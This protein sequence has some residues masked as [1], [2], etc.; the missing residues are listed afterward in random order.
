[1]RLLWLI[2]NVQAAGGPMRAA[3]FDPESPDY[4]V[5]DAILTRATMVKPFAD[6]RL[7]AHDRID[8]LEKRVK[9]VEIEQEVSRGLLPR[10][11]HIFIAEYVG[12]EHRV[13]SMGAEVPWSPWG[14]CDGRHNP[15]LIYEHRK[16]DHLTPHRYDFIPQWTAPCPCGKGTRMLYRTQG[17]IESHCKLC[18]TTWEEFA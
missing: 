12:Q 16:R 10:Q 15:A 9:A 17:R 5:L 3:A 11:G 2:D 4:A 18:N 7:P 14:R 6:V 1:M 13:R 8:D